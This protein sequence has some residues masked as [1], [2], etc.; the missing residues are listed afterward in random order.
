MMRMTHVPGLFASSPVNYMSG[1]REFHAYLMTDRGLTRGSYIGPG[2]NVLERIRRGDAPVSGADKVA[3]AHDLRYTLA[4]GDKAAERQADQKMISKLQDPKVDSMLNRAIGRVPIQ[5][6][7]AAERMGIMQRGSFSKGPAINEEEKKMVETKLDELEMEG[8]G[9]PGARLRNLIRQKGGAAG[10]PPVP[11]DLPIGIDPET[12]AQIRNIAMS[13]NVPHRAEEWIKKQNISAYYEYMGVP[14]D[15]ASAAAFGSEQPWNGI[16]DQGQAEV[17]ETRAP[18]RRRM[19]MEDE[20]EDLDGYYKDYHHPVKA[21]RK[22]PGKTISKQAF[23]ER[24]AEGR[25]KAAAKRKRGTKKP[26]KKRLTATKRR[27]LT[28]RARQMFKRMGRGL[29]LAGEG[30]K[31]AGEG[32]HLP[33]DVDDYTGLAKSV[34]DHAQKHFRISVPAEMVGSLGEEMSGMGADWASLE[35]R[36]SG[37]KSL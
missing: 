3:Q 36:L 8:F 25:R 2:T 23:L 19:D 31:L 24:M 35:S 5:A 14:P 11:R 28:K 34:A 18:K 6:K 32:F 27:V 4:N 13:L 21:P 1:G 7:V 15:E 16:I 22:R 20:P 37:L 17:V 33:D 30:L 26:T 29:G 12:M 10:L 9:K